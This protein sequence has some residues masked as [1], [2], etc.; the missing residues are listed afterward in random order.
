LTTEGP[1]PE[2]VELFAVVRGYQQSRALTVAAELGVADLVAEGPV[3]VDD[4][5]AA[6]GTHGPTLYRVLRALAAIGVFTE[7]GDRRFGLTAMGEYLRSDHPLSLRPV[8]MMLG[9]D[10]EWQAW[11]ELPGCTRTG[12]NGAVLALGVD[13]WEHRRR[14]PEHGDVF[15]GA[16]RT[17][18]RADVPPILRAHDFTRYGTIADVGGGTGALLAAVLRTV[19]DARG[20]LFDQP[21]VVAGSGPVLEEAGVAGRVSVVGGSFFEDVP[22]GADLYVLRRILHDWEDGEAAAI[23]RSVRR[24]MGPGARLVVVEAV[25]GPPGE[26]EV[27]KFRDLLM[28]V[29]P[30]GRER[31]EPEWE[32]LLAASGFELVGTTPASASSTIIEA[33]PV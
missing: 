15:D 26:D 16:M 30:G 25:V 2:Y 17:F 5:A 13:V 33:V 9:A 28:L 1:P 7:D 29:S 10:Y 11:G 21:Q 19:P 27:T 12:D 20:I 32:A 6:T 8:S 14:H 23:L 24:A 18:S 4:L 3:S 22:P 31:T